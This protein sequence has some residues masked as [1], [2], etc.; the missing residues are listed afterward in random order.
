M[1]PSL[2]DG[3]AFKRNLNAEFFTKS[4]FIGGKLAPE[5]YF[6]RSIPKGVN[7]TLL[8]AEASRLNCQAIAASLKRTRRRI[9]VVA[10][11]VEMSEIEEAY[12]RA[13]PDV[14]VVNASLKDGPSAGFHVTRSLRSKHRDARI[15]LLVDSCERAVVVEAFRSGARGILSR[16]EPVETLCKCIRRVNEG[17]IWASNR[18]LEFVVESIADTAPGHITDARGV[19][20][21]TKREQT[22]VQLVAEGRT[23]RDIAHEL[24]LSEHT[25][26][27]YL[28]RIFNKLGTSSRLEL[29]LYAINRRETEKESSAA[30]QFVPA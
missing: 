24:H 15:I 21:L 10:T 16:D 7:T 17:Q 13:R 9:T 29:A 25:V 30:D 1:H 19:S 4:D 22:L 11:C 18:Q 6:D 3:S 2:Y 5:L 27:N 8:I 14:C 28:F 20:L 26:R 12:P 23:N